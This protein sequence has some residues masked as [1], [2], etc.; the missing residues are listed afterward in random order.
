M[1]SAR[2]YYWLIGQVIESLDHPGFATIMLGLVKYYLDYAKGP[3][4]LQC[5][6]PNATVLSE[7]ANMGFA[8]R[9]GYI[10][11][12]LNPKGSFSF[13]IPLKHIF[14]FCEDYDKVMY[15]MS[16]TLTLVRTGMMVMQYSKLLLQMLD[17]LKLSKI[18]RM[19]PR[20]PNDEMKYK[21]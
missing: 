9:R 17:K 13:G 4:L 7:D 12:K 15:G 1:Y 14:G 8:I 11:K 3:G 21:L 18:S 16:H 2:V 6:Y 20:L 10:V 5:R 19:M